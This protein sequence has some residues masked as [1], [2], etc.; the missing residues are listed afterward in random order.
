MGGDGGWGDGDT[1]AG[2]FWREEGAAQADAEATEVLEKMF[3][4]FKAFK[5]AA[6]ALKRARQ[7][8]KGSR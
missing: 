1:R 6:S 7:Q 2:D 4:G 3:P 8:D 5:A